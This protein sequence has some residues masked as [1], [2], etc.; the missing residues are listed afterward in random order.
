MTAWAADDEVGATVAAVVDELVLLEVVEA[1]VVV[2]ALA[3]VVVLAAVV[4][5]EL[6]LD[7]DEELA[8]AVLLVLEAAELPVV[9]ATVVVVSATVD[10]EVATV[11]SVV[12]DSA[13]VGSVTAADFGDSDCALALESLS[14]VIPPIP[15]GLSP[16]R[17]LPVST[18]ALS[19]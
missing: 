18:L 8:P 7:D 10:G 4:E 3:V 1:L 2:V 15:D 9:G 5:V 6:E 11:V 17:E 16:S 14:A 19:L 13:R 12:G